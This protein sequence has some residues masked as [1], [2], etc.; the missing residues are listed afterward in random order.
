MLLLFARTLCTPP[1]SL[2]AALFSCTLFK[3]FVLSALLA[4]HPAFFMPLLFV[5]RSLCAALS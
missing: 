4:S 2:Y 3:W 1:L 5:R